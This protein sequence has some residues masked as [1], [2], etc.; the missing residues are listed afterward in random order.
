MRLPNFFIVGAPKTGTT[1]LYHYLRQHPQIYMSP[2]KEPHFFSEEV[3]EE[4]LNNRLRSHYTRNTRG[5]TEFLARPDDRFLYRGIVSRW[6]DYVRLF[7]GAGNAIAVGEASVGYLRS[8]TAPTRIAQMIPQARIVILLRNPIERAFSQYLYGVASGGIR[9]SLREHIERN[10]RHRSGQICAHYPFL[11]FG[12]YADPVR[13]YRSLFGDRVWI[14][15]HNE[16]R[17]QPGKL[18]R[19][20]YTFLGVDPLFEPG[21]RT[22][23]LEAQVPRTPA[24]GWLKWAGVWK[25][26]ARLTPQSLRTPIRRSLMRPAGSASMSLEDR[27]CLIEIYRDDVQKLANELCRD[28]NSWIT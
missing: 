28:L 11:E 18:C 3:R 16:Y 15:W 10:L 14:G 4:N 24:I 26:V 17:D 2:I 21:V 27:H 9:W 5:L 20:L 8:E 25:A 6:E 13:R 12:F 19:D 7:D 23:Y 22:R 1:S